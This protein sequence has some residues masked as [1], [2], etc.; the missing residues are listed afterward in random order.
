MRHK[1]PI[2][3]IEL[4]SD[5][6]HL[7]LKGVFADGV[8][9]NWVID[10]GAS[11]TVFDKNLTEYYEVLH[12]ETDEIHTASADENPQEISMGILSELHFGKRNVVNLKVALMDLTHI[13]KLYLKTTNLEICGLLG[14]DFLMEN[15]AVIDY[16]KKR[17]VLQS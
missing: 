16:K 6:Y 1:I 9:G 14:G 4:E 2:E 8:K 5:N 7:I 13:N 12:G 3:I 15:N 17:I 10:T 11:K